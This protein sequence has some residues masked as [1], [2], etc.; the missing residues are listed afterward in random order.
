MRQRQLG[1]GDHVG[2]QVRQERRHE[3][4][5]Q[6][7]AAQS[8][9]Q[10]VP[11]PRD[12]RADDAHGEHVRAER[13]DAAVGQQQ[14]LEEQDDGGQH[15]HHRR[16]EQH[17][18]QARSGG[19]R[20]RTGHR[21]DFQGRQHE[22]ERA[23]GSQEQSRPRLLL[24][25]LVDSPCAVDDER[26]RGH[27][28]SHR[29]ADGQEALCDMHVEFSSRA[30]DTS[31]MAHSTARRRTAPG[32]SP[33]GL[34]ADG[35]AAPSTTARRPVRRLPASPAAFPSAAG[36]S[37]G[38][39]RPGVTPITVARAAAHL[40]GVPVHRRS[41]PILNRRCPDQ[42]SGGGHSPLVTRRQVHPNAD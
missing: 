12:P 1:G 18:A 17:R 28:P 38:V 41:G 16:P 5:R 25:Q 30:P 14:G 7:S 13:G 2:G 42:S 6:Q 34:L 27:R 31:R 37:G 24:E 29:M 22:R 40:Q 26:G 3:D 20:R 21:R 33:A 10:D 11:A 4:G 9:G 36:R 35:A 23:G 15:G 8:P 39:C 32:R 19:V